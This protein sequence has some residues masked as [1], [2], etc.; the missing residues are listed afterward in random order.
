MRGE[1]FGRQK[2][3]RKFSGTSPRARGKRCRAWIECN[4]IRN[5]PA[6]AG[7]TRCRGGVLLPRQEHPRVRGENEWLTPHL[8]SRG[9]TSPRARGKPSI[10]EPRVKKARNIPACAGK[11]N[12]VYNNGIRK[13][14]HPRVRGENSWV[15]F[16]QF[17]ACGTSPRARGK[18]RAIGF[19]HIPRRNIPA[20]AGKT[21]ARGNR[22]RGG[23][24]HPRVRGENRQP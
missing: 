21:V 7:K 8:P 10:F 18:L 15:A 4:S 19:R 6:C 3:H 22:R 9:G 20:C 11:T 13:A 23:S 2:H 17:N 14:E 12:T 1:N 16:P 5:I 24:E